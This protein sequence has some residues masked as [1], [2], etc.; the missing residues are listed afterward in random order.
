[1]VTATMA[2]P[3]M[4]PTSTDKNSQFS[5]LEVKDRIGDQRGGEWES[6]K[7]LQEN[8][9]NVPNSTRRTSLLTAKVTQVKWQAQPRN[10]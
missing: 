2:K 8:K 3:E 5:S 1:M 6:L 4:T 7:I 10:G 9:A